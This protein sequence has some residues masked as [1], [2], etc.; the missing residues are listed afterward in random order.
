MALSIYVDG[1]GGENS[2]YGYFVK[3]TGESFYEKKQG[4]TN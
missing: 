2:G 1:S 3:E 4:I